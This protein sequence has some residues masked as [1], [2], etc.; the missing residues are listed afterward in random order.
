M[1]V[2][3]C[4][5][6]CDIQDSL[7]ANAH[8]VTAATLHSKAFGSTQHCQTH[9]RVLP[10]TLC[11]VPERVVLDGGSTL[12]RSPRKVLFLAPCPPQ[13]SA[14]ALRCR[15]VW[16][17]NDVCMIDAAQVSHRVLSL[18]PCPPPQVSPKGSSD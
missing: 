12:P 9:V 7:L 4:V 3:V 11:T 13:E 1:L 10:L 6:H 15:F 16:S 5:T 2:C 18:T 8:G 17:P 14:A